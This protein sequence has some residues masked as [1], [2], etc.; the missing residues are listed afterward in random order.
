MKRLS[1]ITGNTLS[2]MKT[3][4]RGTT[5]KIKIWYKGIQEGLEWLGLVSEDLSGN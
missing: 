2:H 5:G 4:E 3:L 1:Q